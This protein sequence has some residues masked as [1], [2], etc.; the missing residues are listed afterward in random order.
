[1]WQS[2]VLFRSLPE[3]SLKIRHAGT[4][5]VIRVGFRCGFDGEDGNGSQDGNREEGQRCEGDSQVV[6]AWREKAL[7]CLPVDRLLK[8]RRAQ[9]CRPEGFTGLCSFLCGSSMSAITGPPIPV[10]CPPASAATQLYSKK[11][12]LKNMNP[13]F[14]KP[15]L[16]PPLV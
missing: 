12:F 2:S 11:L 13:R 10:W 16:S 4:V 7:C 9:G 3:E 14:T 6:P 8:S 5:Q 1:M 15:F